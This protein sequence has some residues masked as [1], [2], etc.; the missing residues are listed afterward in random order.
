MPNPL[1]QSQIPTPPT[2]Q[3]GNSWKSVWDAFNANSSYLRS[4]VLYL[5]TYLGRVRAAITPLQFLPISIANAQSPYA[6]QASDVL[7][8]ASAGTAAITEIDLPSAT[9]SGRA[10]VVAKIDAHVEN[11]N[12]VAAG[13]DTINGSA[14]ASLTAQYNVL[15]VVD[16]TAGLWIE[17]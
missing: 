5:Q 9:G 15:R 8:L 7:I 14:S 12:V 2:V 1:F 10:L 6:V 3:Q 11:V 16:A 13:S 17:W 4:L